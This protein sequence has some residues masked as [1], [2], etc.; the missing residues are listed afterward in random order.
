MTDTTSPT[1]G[2]TPTPLLVHGTLTAYHRYGCRCG[3]CRDRA[4]THDATRRRLKAY[5]QW[6][7]RTDAER[8]RIHLRALQ[9]VPLT[10]QEIALRSG[11][12]PN[13][14]KQ[15]LHDGWRTVRT[16]DAEAVLN[17]PVP[18]KPVPSG[19]R[20]DATA[21]RRRIQ[22]LM[23]VGYP[24]PAIIRTTGTAERRLRDVIHDRQ[25]TVEATTAI[26]VETAYDLLWDKDPLDQGVWL[27]DAARARATAARHRWAPP[28]AWDDDTIADPKA[29]PDWTGR[30]GTPGGYYDHTQI[31]T[32]TCQPCR[33]AVAQAALL[34][35]T[36]RRARNAA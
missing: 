25:G 18:T 6:K 7:P 10:R 33:D 3:L 29:L 28:A 16:A 8:V 23:A 4:V 20:T 30:C 19:A 14:I 9:L 24:M 11:L 26:A 17:I 35:K 27:R 21:T 15:I 22:A 34:R 5:G 1:P 12:N 13:R 32:P 2:G 36:R 31:G